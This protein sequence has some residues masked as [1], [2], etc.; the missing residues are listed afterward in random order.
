MKEKMVLFLKDLAKGIIGAFAML[1]VF[2]LVVLFNLKTSG[3]ISVYEFKEYLIA[4]ATMLILGFGAA[5]SFVKVRAIVKDENKEEKTMRIIKSSGI[6]WII[7]ITLMVI[8]L[9]PDLPN[10]WIFLL[11]A[12]I[13]SA[14]YGVVVHISYKQTISK[15][16]EKI[17][18]KN[19]N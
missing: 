19:K 18:E 15:I 2:S 13:F 8:L 1:G 16:N 4:G 6:T 10:L 12:A 17:K 14:I 11:M 5:F 7:T 3:E 9:I